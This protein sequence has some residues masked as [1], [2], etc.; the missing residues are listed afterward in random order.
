MLSWTRSSGRGIVTTTGL[1]SRL[2]I[3]FACRDVVV[4]INRKEQG[5]D[6]D[7]TYQIRLW[8]RGGRTI[9]LYSQPVHGSRGAPCART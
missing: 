2:R 1:R 9:P 5:S 8:L 7:P 6:G 4:V 3:E